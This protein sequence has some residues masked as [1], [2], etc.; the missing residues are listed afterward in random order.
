MKNYIVTA[1]YETMNLSNVVKEKDLKKIIKK[2]FKEYEAKKIVY[3]EI[4]NFNEI[5]YIYNDNINLVI[6]KK[7][8]ELSL[9][10]KKC[11]FCK[12]MCDFFKS[13]KL[14]R[15]YNW[16]IEFENKYKDFVINLINKYGFKISNEKTR[17]D[18]FGFYKLELFSLNV[19]F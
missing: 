9:Q 19:E 17:I 15:F 13:D 8:N 10:E 14:Y 4:T 11:Y 5:N 6:T 3:R 7:I 16:H 12:E 1:Y 18:D 2:C